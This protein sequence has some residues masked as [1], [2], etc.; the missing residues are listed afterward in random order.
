MIVDYLLTNPS[1]QEP[2]INNLSDS[3]KIK[4]QLVVLGPERI[5]G[6]GYNITKIKNAM[7][8]TIFNRED[9]NKEIYSIF[10]VG[11]K[12][13]NKFAKNSLGEIY[14]SGDFKGTPKATDLGRWFE[15]KLCK[16]TIDGKRENGFEI[17]KR[18]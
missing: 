4:Q 9:L 7:G 5:K 6:L 2:I 11:K 16:V 3:D 8:I 17:I 13:S 1:L 18:K 10:E 14:K 15:I 12:Y